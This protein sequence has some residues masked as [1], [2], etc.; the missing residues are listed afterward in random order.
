MNEQFIREKYLITEEKF[1]I[2]QHK[3][4]IIFGLGGVGGAAALS[5]VRAGI[6]KIDVVDFDKFDITNLNRQVLANLNTIGKLKTDVF[7]EQAKLINPNCQI[8]KHNFLFTTDTY[9]LINLNEYDYV[10]DAIDNVSAKIYLASYCFKNGIK[11]IT[12]LGTGKRL[13]PTKFVVTDIYKTTYD[14][15]ARVMR[16]K[17]KEARVK[18]L[19][20]VFSTEQPK[21]INSQAIPSIS[22]V[23]PVAG[24][25][26]ASYVINDIIKEEN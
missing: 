8:T 4:I 21:K 16:K 26:L 12:S 24:Y 18:K 17:L 3:R 23:P 19:N 25:I 2:V 14:P 9:S 6:T 15:I 7:E 5:L 13:D 20:V 10:I 1:N 11:I 22:F